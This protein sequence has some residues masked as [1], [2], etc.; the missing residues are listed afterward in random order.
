[1]LKYNFT[2][3]STLPSLRKRYF[4][5]TLIIGLLIIGVVLIFFFDTLTTKQKAAL[6]V[7]MIDKRFKTLVQIDGNIVKIFQNINS[8][9]LDPTTGNHTNLASQWISDSIQKSIELQTLMIND[10]SPAIISS[11]KTLKNNFIKFETD[12]NSLVKL[13]VDINQQFPGLALAAEKMTPLQRSISS[14]LKRMIYEIESGELEPITPNLHQELLKTYINWINVISQVRIYYTNRF[15]LFSLNI[16][17]DQIESLIN[18]HNKFLAYVDKLEP[19]YAIEDSFEG[20]KNLQAMRNDS[21]AWLNIF[22]K[23]RYISESDQWRG[24]NYMMQKL[25]LP[26]LDVIS[27]TI[28]NLYIH[29]NQHEVLIKNQLD[30]SITSLLIL[31]IVIISLFL[32]FIF[33]ILFSLDRMIFNPISSVSKA[34]ESRAFNRV[35]PQLK[36]GKTQEISHLIEAFQ[37]MDEKVNHRQSEL[38][39]Q[40]LHDHLTGLPNRFLLNQRLDYQILASE[41]NNTGFNLFFL[42]LDRFKD[43]NDSLGHATGDLLLVEVAKILSENVRKTDTLARLGGD[44]FAILLPDSKRAEVIELADKLTKV[45]HSPFVINGKN[46]I[47]G[48]S[49]GIVNY[50]DDGTDTKNLLQHADIA[51]YLAKRNKLDYSLYDNK[52]DFYS[53]NR[54]TLINDLC[55]AIENDYLEIYFQPQIHITSNQVIGAEALLRWQHPEFGFINPEKIIELAEYSGNIHQ[56]THWVLDNAIQ[57]CQQWSKHGYSINISV[58]LSA[59]DFNNQDLCRQIKDL[60]I[61]YQLSGEK[62]TLEI[63]ENSMMENM[64][65]SIEVLN[66]LNEMAINLSIDDFGTGFSSLAYLKQLPV[67]ELKIDKSFVLEMDKNDNDRVIVQSIIQLGHNLGLE[68]VAEGIEGQIHLDL[69]RA[70]GCD[71]AQGY[72]F[73]KPQTAEQ[74]LAFLDKRK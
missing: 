72:L 71:I 7:E 36:A 22:Y 56:L 57:Q 23:V 34:L 35:A 32:L 6:Q 33:A 63:T 43:V 66:T 64:G 60:L 24:D 44:E 20:Q 73:G 61:K 31:L 67:N 18:Y 49:I 25:I 27:E 52:D 12:Y 14:T 38:E 29:I 13:R 62:L 30:D 41:R 2:K 4:S 47:I 53:Q 26:Q 5:Q 42:D 39:Y 50:P 1:M 37:E 21:L 48:S 10:R 17:T 15:A 40:V 8:F 46:I 19:I 70:F 65:R 74:F 3:S 55:H 9:L 69:N 11:I 16:M 59:Y 58:N 54:L 45:L 51:M 68:I 28:N